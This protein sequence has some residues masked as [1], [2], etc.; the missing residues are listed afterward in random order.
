MR[1][2]MLMRFCVGES[3]GAEGKNLFTYRI[4]IFCQVNQLKSN[5]ISKVLIFYYLFPQSLPPRSTTVSS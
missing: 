4:K 3:G 5:K 1:C 2:G